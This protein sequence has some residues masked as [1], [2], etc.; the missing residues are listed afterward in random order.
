MG[1]PL[2]YATSGEVPPYC[3]ESH[4]LPFPVA[5]GGRGT[6]QVPTEMSGQALIRVAM[7]DIHHRPKGNVNTLALELST[8]RSSPLPHESSVESTSYQEQAHG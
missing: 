7:S 1:H 6:H 3:E 2:L 8:H 5:T 4:V